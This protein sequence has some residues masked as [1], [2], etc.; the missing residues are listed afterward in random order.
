MGYHS[1][2][3]LCYCVEKLLPPLHNDWGALNMVHITRHYGEVHMFV[4]HGVD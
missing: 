2:K 1:I 4:M 3:E